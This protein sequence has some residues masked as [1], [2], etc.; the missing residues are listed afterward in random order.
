MARCNPKGGVDWRTPAAGS[1][2]SHILMNV[3]RQMHKGG[4]TLAGW[5]LVLGLTS[6]LADD[7]ATPFPA[8]TAGD[9]LQ[10]VTWIYHSRAATAVSQSALPA[11]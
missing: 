9:P 8:A 1:S 2:L 11:P 10:D 3:L 6:A 7:S 5:L 4:T